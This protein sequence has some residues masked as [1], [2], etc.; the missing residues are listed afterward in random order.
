MAE[1]S[2][3]YTLSRTEIEQI[4]SYLSTEQSKKQEFKK[5]AYDQIIL[6]IFSFLIA[7]LWKD[8]LRI[9]IDKLLSKFGVPAAN[10]FY[11]IIIAVLLTFACIQ[12]IDSFLKQN[13][14]KEK[15]EI[16]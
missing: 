7:L 11:E 6:M 15:F 10:Y 16:H 14:K 9:G 8:A 3:L 5:G 4:F 13:R 12:C 1:N 2:E